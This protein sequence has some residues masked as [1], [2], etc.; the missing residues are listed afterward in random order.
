M[1]HPTGMYQC[2]R[3]MY[4]C[5]LQGTCLS[6]VILSYNYDLVLYATTWRQCPPNPW[7]LW[8]FL[9]HSSHTTCHLPRWSCVAGKEPESLKL[10]SSHRNL[11]LNMKAWFRSAPHSRSTQYS[12]MPSS[13]A[14]CT[15]LI[16]LPLYELRANSYSGAN[17]AIH[18]FITGFLVGYN[19]V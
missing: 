6:D 10:F 3:W 7:I 8:L 15:T 16:G 14:A 4:Y 5:C 9:S 12:L 13:S 11:Q 17:I 18:A 19:P 1:N 2:F